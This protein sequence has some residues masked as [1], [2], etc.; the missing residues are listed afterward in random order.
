M[1]TGHCSR[2]V[3]KDAGASSRRKEGQPSSSSKKRQKTYA[4]HGPQEQDCDHW[5]Q[6]EGL[7]SRGGRHFG[8]PSQLG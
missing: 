6:G 8:D 1:V 3:R 4:S 2:L 7:S 5:G